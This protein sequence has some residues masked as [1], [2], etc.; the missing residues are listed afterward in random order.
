MDTTCD[1]RQ[2]VEQI[3]HL[4]LDEIQA[5]IAANDA[6]RTA[7]LELRRVAVRTQRGQHK[8]EARR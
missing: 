4:S 6:E 8:T 5:R 2:I 7:L 1:I 3:R